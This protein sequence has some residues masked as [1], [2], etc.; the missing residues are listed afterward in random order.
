VWSVAF[1]LPVSNLLALYPA[2]AGQ[3]LFTPEHNLYAPLAG[4]A[5]LIAV[6]TVALE[7]RSVRPWVVIGLAC[8]VTLACAARTIVRLGDWRDE[9]RLFA[10][11]VAVG[12]ASPRVWY[13][14]QRARTRRRMERAADA[15]RTALRFAPNDAE[16]WTNL[17]VTASR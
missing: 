12:S 5:V 17:G 1:Y 2:I 14:R 9:A 11:A 15:Y 10:S 13:N 4:L 16:A 3:W 7:A 8:A 6:A